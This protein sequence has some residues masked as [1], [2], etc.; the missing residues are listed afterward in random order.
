MTFLFFYFERL[1]Y[2]LNYF[3]IKGTVAP[4]RAG[5]SQEPR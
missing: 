3:G 5:G 4:T 2:T 1:D